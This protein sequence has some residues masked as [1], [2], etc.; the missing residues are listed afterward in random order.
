VRGIVGRAKVRAIEQHS[1]IWE[2]T[3]AGQIHV[4]LAPRS[5]ADREVL[6]ALLREAFKNDSWVEIG[7]GSG[8]VVDGRVAPELPALETGLGPVVAEF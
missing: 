6:L 7:G 2:G 4:R 5:P 3:P 1:H 8:T